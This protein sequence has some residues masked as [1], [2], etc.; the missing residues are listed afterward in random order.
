MRS[1]SSDEPVLPGEIVQISSGEYDDYF[2]HGILVATQ[3]FDLREII[4]EAKSNGPISGMPERVMDIL[5]VRGLA[6]TP[7]RHEVHD[8][9]DGE[10]RC[11]RCG[12][13]LGP[14]RMCPNCPGHAQSFVNPDGDACC[15]PMDED[16]GE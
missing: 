14:F 15:P 1:H 4:A 11:H 13:A 8:Y 16:G 12:A 5:L 6:S 2:T 10:Y 7:R 9:E 3:P